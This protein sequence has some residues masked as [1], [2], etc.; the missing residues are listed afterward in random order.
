MGH[1]VGGLGKPPRGKTDP[2]IHGRQSFISLLLQPERATHA[3]HSFETPGS[4]LPGYPRRTRIHVITPE[5]ESSG[6]GPIPQGLRPGIEQHESREVLEQL[7]GMA[8]LRPQEPGPEGPQA[9]RFALGHQISQESLQS[10]Q[11]S[12]RDEAH[13]MRLLEAN[14]T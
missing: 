12:R 13:L 8:L 5:E 10:C 6:S 9:S 2:L 1:P 3:S 4:R 11:L 14:H 7:V